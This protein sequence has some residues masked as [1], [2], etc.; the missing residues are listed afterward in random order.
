MQPYA[1]AGIAAGMQRTHVFVLSSCITVAASTEA[2]TDD[3]SLA[4]HP[5]SCSRSTQPELILQ[6]RREGGVFMKYT[7]DAC[8]VRLEEW[9]MPTLFTA[10]G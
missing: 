6:A 7:S 10:A 9:P 2:S 5:S 8:L 1:S 3:A 4:N